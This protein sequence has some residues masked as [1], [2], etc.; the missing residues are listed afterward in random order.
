MEDEALDFLA[1]RLDDWARH[2]GISVTENGDRLSVRQLSGE[3]ALELLGLLDAAALPIEEIRDAGGNLDRGDLD[4]EARNVQVRAT[5][6]EAP[7]GV[8]RILTLAAFEDALRRD[9]LPGRVWVRR[10]T[11][12]FDTMAMRYGPWGD[13]ERQAP[14][15]IARRLCLHLRETDAYRAR[16]DSSGR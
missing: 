4:A 10:L 2:A 15:A 16:R 5:L 11:L 3:Q 6:P 9:V 8:E 13:G 12:P 7:A 14:A 1:E